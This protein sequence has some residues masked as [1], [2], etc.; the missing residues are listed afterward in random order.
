LQ[1][2]IRLWDVRKSADSLENGTVL[3]ETAY[4]IGH[5]SLGDPCNDEKLLVV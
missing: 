2:C 1:G 4:D 5:F 3:A